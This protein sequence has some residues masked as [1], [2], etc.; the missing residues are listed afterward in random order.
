MEADER[1][2]CVTEPD[3]GH[4]VLSEILASS[5]FDVGILDLAFGRS[6]MRV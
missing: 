3:T 1:Q 6:G 4:K 2:K 5:E